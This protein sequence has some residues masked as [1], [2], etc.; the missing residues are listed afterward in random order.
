MVAEHRLPDP[1]GFGVRL[2]TAS[3]DETRVLAAR[4]AALLRGGETI[5]LHGPLG[6]GKT[7][8][9]QGLCAALGIP[10][11]VT[12]PTFTLANRYE[13][14]LV[15]HH[16]DFYRIGPE[17]DLADIGVDAL[18]DE[19]EAGEAVLVAEW[20]ERLAPLVKPRLEFLVLPGEA[21]ETRIWYLRGIPELPGPWIELATDLG[22]GR[23]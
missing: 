15:V 12:S 22:G 11:E 21:P 19:V 10:D 6:A 14:R 3:P 5:L 20:P 9:V 2:R 8:F 18:L 17:A 13:G 16:L 1:L 7:C 4:A 23:C